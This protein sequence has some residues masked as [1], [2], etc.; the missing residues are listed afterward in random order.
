M[1]YKEEQDGE[2]EALLSI[3]EGEM[4]VV[5]ESPRHVFTMP[6]KTEAYD[7]DE[8]NSGLFVLLKFTYTEKY[9]EEKPLLEAEESDDAGEAGTMTELLQHLDEQM[10]ENLGM[11]MVF[12]VVSAAMEWIGSRWEQMQKNRQEAEEKRK[13]ELEAE[14]RVRPREK[15]KAARM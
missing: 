6:V 11:V 12:T 10:E 7:P 4:Q 3:Y 9:P 1:D 5:S 13:E 2:I 15:E 8:D 14:E